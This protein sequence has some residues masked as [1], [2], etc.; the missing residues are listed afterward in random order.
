MKQ[1]YHLERLNNYPFVIFH[2]FAGYGEQEGMNK[3]M[4]YLGVFNG[5]AKKLFADYDTELYIPSMSGV[6]SMW[7][8]A[9][10]MYAQIKGGTVDYGKV[11]SEKYGHERY[12]RTFPGCLPDWGTLDAEG[13]MRKINVIGHSFGGPT[14]RFFVNMVINGCQEEIDGTPE[15]ELSE[16]FKGGHDNWIHSCTTFAGANDGISFLYA[17]E[18]VVPPV[19]TAVL[20]GLSYM[21]QIPAA[22]KFYDQNLEQWGITRKLQTGEP[23]ARNWKQRVQ[24]YLYSG[25]CV[26][27]DLYIHKFRERSKDWQPSDKVYYFAYYAS[28]T[29]A[30]KNGN[31]KARWG[32]DPIMYFFSIPVGKFDG[33]KADENHAEIGPEWKENDGLVNV[34]SGRAPHSK[35]WTEWTGDKDLKPGIWY[36]MPIEDKD[37]MSYM[38]LLES[39]ADYAIFLYDL[40][41]RIDNLPSIDE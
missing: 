26:L 1:N 17:I 6:S 34:M 32:M 11:H 40:L 2:G 16:F 15:G 30:D 23:R 4:P 35:P 3:V 41:R 8:R 5:N 37:H 24:D 18:K 20:Q 25:D 10:E 29:K 27:D 38:G 22:A 13:K 31:Q 28:K 9:C 12:G 7:D 39:R 21:A 19:A 14:V 33:C 36:Q